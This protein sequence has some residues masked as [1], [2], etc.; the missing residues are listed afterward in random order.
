MHKKK[1]G[2]LPA[3]LFLANSKLLFDCAETL[4]VLALQIVKQPASLA[5]H[6]IQPASGVMIL[7]VLTKMLSQFID[8]VGENSD[9]DLGRPG[10]TFMGTILI[11]YLTLLFECNGHYGHL[12]FFLW[13]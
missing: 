3:F 5:Y 10:V 4:N 13:P 7:L 2:G 9:L 8:A 12:L 1:S 6:L 11:D